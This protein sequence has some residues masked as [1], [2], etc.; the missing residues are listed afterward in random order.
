VPLVKDM[1][2]SLEKG[3]TDNGG[4]PIRILPM[5]APEPA[6]KEDSSSAGQ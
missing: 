4:G 6:V 3:G 2:D 5:S 1:L